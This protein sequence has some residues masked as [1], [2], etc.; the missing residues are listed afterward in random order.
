MNP[1]TERKDEFVQSFKKKY[2][3]E[4]LDL[5]DEDVN[6]LVENVFKKV[7]GEDEL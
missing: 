4:I 7:E 6:N 1:H 5:T 3:D 2:P